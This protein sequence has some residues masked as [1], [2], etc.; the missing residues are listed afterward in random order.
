[1]IFKGSR[2]ENVPVLTIEVEPGRTESYLA[3]RTAPPTLA[4]YHHTFRADERLDLLAFRFYRNA[5][6]F[7]RIAD[8]NDEM[9]PEELLEPGRQILI[10]PDQT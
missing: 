1:M 5:E 7:W 9:D 3:M 2:Y 4:G 10:P 6:K 8:A